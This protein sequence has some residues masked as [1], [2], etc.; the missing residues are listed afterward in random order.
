MLKVNTSLTELSLR[1]N[2]VGGNAATLL[3]EALAGGSS[4]ISTTHLP[5]YLPTCL[6]TCIVSVPE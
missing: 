1:Y 4:G 6:P 5:T 3:A 2:K